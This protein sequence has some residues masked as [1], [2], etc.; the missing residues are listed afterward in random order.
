MADA[1]IVCHG[2]F[3][4]PGYRESRGRAIVSCSMFDAGSAWFENKTGEHSRPSITMF[5]V[6]D[7]RV[8]DLRFIEP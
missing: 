7:S 6:R 2:H 8:Y 3:H 5:T 1:R 4:Q